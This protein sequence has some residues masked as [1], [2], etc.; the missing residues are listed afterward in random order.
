MRRLAAT[1]LFCAVAAGCVSL[2]P[3][4][5]R[6]ADEVRAMADATA[7]VYRVRR[8]AVLVG[9]NVDGVGGTYRR[10]LFTITT[11]MLTSRHRDAIVAHELAHYLL[12]H[13]RPF[14]GT[15]SLDWQREQ[16]L[17]ELDANAKA[18]EILMRVRGLPEAEALRIVYEHLLAFNRLVVARRTVIPWG[19]RAPCEE[20][21]DLLSR[22][23]T[24]RAWSAAV[25]C[26]QVG[27]SGGGNDGASRAN[28]LPG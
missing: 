28:S 26:G 2:T 11:D 9:G 18:V 7:R 16:E 21:A 23:P 17:R 6:G 3:A 1:L 19:H 4:Q 14:A 24:Y 20:I 8:I 5:Q 27:S 22:F 13:D 10:G 25:P 15:L 12:D